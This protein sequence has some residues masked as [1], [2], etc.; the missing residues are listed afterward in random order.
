[1]R[2]LIF[3]IFMISIYGCDSNNYTGQSMEDT[4]L[5]DFSKELNKVNFSELISDEFK[6]VQLESTE[7]SLIGHVNKVL[8]QDEYIFVF[9]WHM[10]K[11][12]FMFS[13]SGKFIRKIGESGPGPEELEGPSDFFIDDNLIY[14]L[15]MGINIKIFNFEGEFVKSQ[16]V[17]SIGAV[18]FIK[19]SG[20]EIYGFI[21]GN[22]DH[23][24]KITNGDFNVIHSYFPYQNR[25]LDKI[26]INPLYRNESDGKIIYRRNLNDTLY[27][28]T[29]K[30]D[31]M[32]YRFF[33]FGDKSIRNTQIDPATEKG[34]ILQ[35]KT[36]SSAQIQFYRES[37]LAGY[38]V[39]EIDNQYWITIHSKLS[40][41][42]KI[43]KYTSFINDLTFEKR[44]YPIGV[45]KD[46][47]VY[48]I[49]PEFLLEGIEKNSENGNAVH[50][51]IKEIVNQIQEDSNPILLYVKFDF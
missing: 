48:V 34:E 37:N 31:L 49:E 21:G 9:D 46:Y 15:D 41:K 43:F 30:G 18:N 4:V 42:T 14:I 26:I 36:G 35:Y 32:P 5:I 16:R 17:D 24:L 38:L 20:A 27:Q 28:I 8:F 3:L 45:D 7:N 13:N 22:A 39:F 29:S 40:G 11:S 23:N 50:P 51:K 10:A 6:V 12:I 44:S 1:M 25:D 33:D 19:L 47:F 2:K